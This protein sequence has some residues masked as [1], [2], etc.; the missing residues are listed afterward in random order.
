[1]HTDILPPKAQTDGGVAF[2]VHLLDDAA[3]CA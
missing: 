2:D 3:I 1:M